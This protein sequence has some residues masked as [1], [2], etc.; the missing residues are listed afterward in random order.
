MKREHAI[1]IGIA[2][3]LLTAGL[4]IGWRFLTPAG[5]TVAESFRSWFWEYRSLD[6]LV[7]VGLIFA[8]ALGI[9]ALLP[10]GSGEDE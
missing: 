6:L 9:T 10:R 4:A 8:G 3:L 2:I 1:W 5:P 7:Q